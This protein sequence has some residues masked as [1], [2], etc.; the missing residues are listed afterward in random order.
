MENV[1]RLV[2][3]RPIEAINTEQDK[4]IQKGDIVLY[5]SI[6]FNSVP[7]GLKCKTNDSYTR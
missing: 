4:K 7:I 6:N 3:H 5:F 2:Q 1:T